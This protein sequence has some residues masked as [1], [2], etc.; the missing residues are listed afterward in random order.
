MTTGFLGQP[1]R[2]EAARENCSTPKTSYS[3]GPTSVGAKEVNGKGKKKKKRENNGLG[4]FPGKQN[5][6]IINE[7]PPNQGGVPPKSLLSGISEL[8]PLHDGWVSP[9]PPLSEWEWFGQGVSQFHQSGRGHKGQ[10]FLIQE[11]SRPRDGTR[12]PDGTIRD[13]KHC[14]DWMGQF[15]LL[16]LGEGWVILPTMRRAVICVDHKWEPL[17]H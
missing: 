16:A 7:H 8:L 9:V 11:F 14:C 12:G 4:A 10:V 1:Y 17:N 13:F 2:Q 15:G 6:G 3:L 5:L